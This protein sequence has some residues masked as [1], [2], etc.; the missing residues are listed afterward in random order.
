MKDIPPIPRQHTR[1]HVSIVAARSFKT[2]LIKAENTS[3]YIIFHEHI[4]LQSIYE[5]S[6]EA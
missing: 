1:R 6:Y 3:E 2:I 5:V 4:V